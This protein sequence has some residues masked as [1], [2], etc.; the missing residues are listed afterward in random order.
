MG[1]D[2]GG[3]FHFARAGFPTDDLRAR[4]LPNIYYDTAASPLMYDNGIWARAVPALGEERVLFGSDF[5]LNL[6]PRT[7]VEAEMAQ[8]AA[9]G[10]AGGGG[11]EIL[12]GNAERVFQLRRA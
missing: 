7:A 2:A 10:R 6:Y 3:R 1:G 4:A 9:G 5:P 8:F 11:E 12:G